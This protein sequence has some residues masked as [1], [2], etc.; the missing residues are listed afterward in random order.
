MN[1]VYDSIYILYTLVYALESVLSSSY[2]ESVIIPLVTMS[3][4]LTVFRDPAY[5]TMVF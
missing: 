1:G 5:Q 4:E 2:F 3:L